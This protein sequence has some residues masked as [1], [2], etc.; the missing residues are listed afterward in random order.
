MSKK[1]DMQEEV[2]NDDVM[3][4]P[5]ETEKPCPSQNLY[6]YDI[7]DTVYVM[8][9]N[10]VKQFVIAKRVVLTVNG[11]DGLINEVYYDESDVRS[12][13]GTY[14]EEQLYPSKKALL[15]SL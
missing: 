11:N 13:R 7:G 6:K 15:S 9:N 2:I 8:E 14:K 4:T 10:K 1:K 5:T 3:I 12:L